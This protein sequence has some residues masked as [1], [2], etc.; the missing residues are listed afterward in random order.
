[1][2]LKRK[3]KAKR[4]EKQLL[5]RNKRRRKK[6]KEELKKI[7]GLRKSN[8]ELSS[9]ES[10]AE[11]ILQSSCAFLDK[12]NARM[13]KGLA[14]KNIDEIEDAQK[15]IQ[16]AQEKQKKGTKGNGN[17]VYLKKENKKINL[18]RRLP[19]S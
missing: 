2:I 11:E 4:K 14:D 13:A 18:K 5:Q 15:I 3:K 19:R 6:Q 1:M 7:E 17:C 16:L 10:K 8:K 9:K 12:G